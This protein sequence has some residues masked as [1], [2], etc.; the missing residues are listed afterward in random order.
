MAVLSETIRLTV[1]CHAIRII[2]QYNERP[3]VLLQQSERLKEQK[4]EAFEK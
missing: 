4:T 2:E 1:C 3:E